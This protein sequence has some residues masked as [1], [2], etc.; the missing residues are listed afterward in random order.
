MSSPADE[1][2]WVTGPLLATVLALGGIR[3][4]D[5]IRIKDAAGSSISNVPDG[6][7]GVVLSTHSGH[8]EFLIP[9]EVRFYNHENRSRLSQGWWIWKESEITAWRR[10]KKTAG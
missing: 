6:S 8:S 3:P 1:D 4:G 5:E 2:G 7:V 10:P 9:Y